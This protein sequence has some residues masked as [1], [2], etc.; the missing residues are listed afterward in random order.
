MGQSQ[1]LHLF[2]AHGNCQSFE[3]L[4]GDIC[5][6]EL[7]SGQIDEILGEGDT[8][9]RLISD[10]VVLL[11]YAVIEDQCLQ[12]ETVPA[13][14]QLVHPDVPNQAVLNKQLFQFYAAFGHAQ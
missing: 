14:T 12:G 4:W 1:R 5:V 8:G 10:L 2:D 6:S 13:L 11:L 7:E 9:E 3:S